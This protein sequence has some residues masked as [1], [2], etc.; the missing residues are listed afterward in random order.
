MANKG[1][2]F[3]RQLKKLFEENGFSVMRGAASKGTVFNEKAD[4]IAT[5]ETPSNTKK[6]YMLIVQ[7]K[8]SKRRKK[9]ANNTN[10][11]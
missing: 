8:V 9:N 7:C 6:A 10:Q 11:Q 4:L 3:E 1:I 2:S 5:L